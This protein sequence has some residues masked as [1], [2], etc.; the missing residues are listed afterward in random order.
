MKVLVADDSAVM[1]KVLIG[2]LQKAGFEDVDEAAD[3]EETVAQAMSEEYDLVLMDW[4]MPTMTGL[5]AVKAIRAGGKQAPIIM[6]STEAE[7]GRRVEALEAGADSYVVKPF[8]PEAITAEIK[9]VL[10]KAS[11]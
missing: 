5:E 9:D 8:T 1:R 2:I 3:G 10:K 4:N 7:K 6:V 11:T